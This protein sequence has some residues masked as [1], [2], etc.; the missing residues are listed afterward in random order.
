MGALLISNGCDLLL[1]EYF[2]LKKSGIRFK[3]I[4]IGLYRKKAGLPE[5]SEKDYQ[6]FLRSLKDLFSRGLLSADF[7]KDYYNEVVIPMNYNDEIKKKIEDTFKMYL[8]MF[9]YPSQIKKWQF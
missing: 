2:N 4:N 6:S 8:D 9:S 1:D 3:C 5:Y 7:L